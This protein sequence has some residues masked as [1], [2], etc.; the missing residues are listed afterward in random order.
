MQ[1]TEAAESHK[2][3]RPS[4]FCI[5]CDEGVPRC[6]TCLLQPSDR[7]LLNYDQQCDLYDAVYR[8]KA[9][10]YSYPQRQLSF[11][12]QQLSDIMEEFRNLLH[13]HTPW[14]D[15]TSRQ[16]I[17]ACYQNL[18]IRGGTCNKVA[19]AIH[20]FEGEFA[21]AYEAIMLP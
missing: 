17:Q 7:I 12:K 9:E 18:C 2:E 5:M 10:P 13:E 15:K 1:S 16:H 4:Y 20:F 21:R 3:I 19:L 6:P 11:T 14:Y 8:Q